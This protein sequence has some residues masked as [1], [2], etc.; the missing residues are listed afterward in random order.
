MIERYKELIEQGIEPREAATLILAEA[1]AELARAVKRGKR[2]K[3]KAKA[4][5]QP[6]VR[7]EEYAPMPIGAK[8]GTRKQLKAFLRRQAQP[9]RKPSKAEREAVRVFNATVER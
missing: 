5:E 8:V 2:K 3:K 4:A 7:D 1:V 6:W 9:P